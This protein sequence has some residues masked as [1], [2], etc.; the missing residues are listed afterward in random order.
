MDEW[1]ASCA[2]HHT[3]IS[4]LSKMIKTLSTLD[5]FCEKAG[6]TSLGSKTLD[7]FVTSQKKFKF[8]IVGENECGK[9]Q[10]LN[11]LFGEHCTPKSFDSFKFPFHISVSFLNI[12]S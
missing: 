12:T 11:L 7:D 6:I 4:S 3:E 1:R 10:F 8:L 2:A 9:K 5:K